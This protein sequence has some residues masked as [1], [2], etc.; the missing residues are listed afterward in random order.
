MSSNDPITRRP[1]TL[2]YYPPGGDVFA[3]GLAAVVCGGQSIYLLVNPGA[4]TVVLPLSLFLVY[5]GVRWTMMRVIV[6]D[7]DITVRNA[8]ST[9]TIPMEQVEKAEFDD[10]NQYGRIVLADGEKLQ[11]TA[12]SKQQGKWAIT[13]I[14]RRLGNL[15]KGVIL[16]AGPESKSRK[17]L[18]WAITWMVVISTMV[19]IAVAGITA[20][21]FV[22]LSSIAMLANT[23]R[24]Q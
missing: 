3:G 23:A 10:F 19:Y 2:V 21:T 22:G 7:T 18:W 1:R 13:A 14:N 16:S 5:L 17:V 11:M 8:L 15:P 4:A 9:R 6:T 24:R 12:V 20:G